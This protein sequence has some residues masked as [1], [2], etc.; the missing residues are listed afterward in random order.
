MLDGVYRVPDVQFPELIFQV[1]GDVSK[2]TNFNR[3]ERHPRFSQLFF[4]LLSGKIQD[5]VIFPRFLSFSLNGLLKQQNSQDGTFWSAWFLA[6]VRGYIYTSKSQEGVF[7][8]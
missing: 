4:F 2:S 8:A 3:F 5:F 6:E 1:F 7:V